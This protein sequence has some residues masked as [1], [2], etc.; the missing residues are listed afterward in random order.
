VI[1]QAVGV[2]FFDPQPDALL[3]TYLLGRSL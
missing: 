2:A 3:E 1:D